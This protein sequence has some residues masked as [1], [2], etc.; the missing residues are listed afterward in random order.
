MGISPYKNRP[1]YDWIKIQKYYDQGHSARECLDRFGFCKETWSGAVKYGRIK[2]RPKL[3]PIGTLLTK[4]SSAHRG[5]IKRRLL[6]DGTLKNVCA[7]CRCLPTW[8]GKPLTLVLDHINGRADDFRMENL[9][10]LCPNCN[11][12]TVTFSGRNKKYKE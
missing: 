1:T 11:S 10:L 6:K 7:I 4:H 5:T 8:N 12:Q 2:A 3:K 9:R